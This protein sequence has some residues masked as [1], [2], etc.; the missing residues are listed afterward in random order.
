MKRPHRK[1]RHEITDMAPR[2][3]GYSAAA[4]FAGI[5]VSAGV[6][7]AV[8]GML[9]HHLPETRPLLAAAQT[10]PW[11]RLEVDAGIDRAKVEAAAER[12]LEGYAW[13]DRTAGTARIPIGRAMQ[14]LAAHGWPDAPQGQ[15][16]R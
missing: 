5:G 3:I 15:G 12:K 13:V 14:I 9:S 16:A 10:P 4:L 2:H 7:A 11:P 1:V 6:V 8:L